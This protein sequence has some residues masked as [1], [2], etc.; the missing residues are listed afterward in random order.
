MKVSIIIPI[1]NTEKYLE[2]CLKSLINQT[3]QNIELII[4]NDGSTDNSYQICQK[5]SNYKNI[6]LINQKNQ[7]VSIA[8]NAGINIATGDYLMFVD[9]DDYIKANMVEVLVNNIK[10]SDL[11]ICEY[12]EEYKNKS[13]PVKI[14]SADKVINNKEA[15]LQT[16]GT[17]GGYS[18]NKLFKATIIKQNKLSFNPNIH[19][20]EDQLF[21]I[22]YL[23]FA[24]SITIINQPLYKYRIR[25]SSITNISNT[26][27]YNTLLI[28]LQQI[29]MIMKENN[30]SDIFIKQSIVEQYYKK[31]ISA[32][33]KNSKE[34]RA[35]FKDYLKSKDIHLKKKL[36]LIIIKDFHF[37]YK[38]HQDIK[39]RI[40]KFYD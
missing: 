4:V 24:K 22:E 30:L 35:M 17:V 27:K 39:K 12:Y 25:K 33:C 14:K 18:W 32:S 36:K 16:F 21:V 29:N 31:S 5:Y 26:K 3:Y 28:S 34:I 9:S 1:Y 38:I 23:K 37:I 2:D 20:L 40:Y 6:K 15:M 13:I 10:E 19:M 8:R 7:G 11:A